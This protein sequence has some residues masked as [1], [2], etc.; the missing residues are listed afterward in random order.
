[1][2]GGG[3]DEKFSLG[4]EFCARKTASNS[5]K[6]WLMQPSLVIHRGISESLEFC[7]YALSPKLGLVCIPTK[8]MREV[9]YSMVYYERAFYGYF[10]RHRKCTGQHNQR[11][12]RAG[13]DWM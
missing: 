3:L 6:N 9:G 4:L 10:Q 8:D 11:N 5:R 13:Y 12:I 1:M 7:R 2:G